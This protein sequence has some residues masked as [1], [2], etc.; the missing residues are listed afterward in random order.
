[1]L[2][3]ICAPCIRERERRVVV[4]RLYMTLGVAADSTTA[5]VALPWVWKKLCKVQLRIICD[6]F[7]AIQDSTLPV[8]KRLWGS[9]SALVTAHTPGQHMCPSP[10]SRPDPQVG[11]RMFLLRV[12][13]LSAQD[14]HWRNA[15]ENYRE[16]CKI[17]SRVS[18]HW[19]VQCHA[20][21]LGAAESFS[22]LQELNPCHPCHCYSATC[23]GVVLALTTEP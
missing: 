8:E 1:M 11:S 13:T 19:L 6:V 18:V 4:S 3:H 22:T 10:G 5:E 17:K 12:K 16:R 2:W 9:T 23:L 14:R 15:R 21:W 7:S 20:K